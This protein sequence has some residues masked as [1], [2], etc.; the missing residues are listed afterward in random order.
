[1]IE[2]TSPASVAS[3]YTQSGQFA[4]ISW[5]ILQDGSL[6]QQ[7]YTGVRDPGSPETNQTS[8][9]AGLDESIYRIYSMTKPVVSSAIIMLVQSDRLSLDTPLANF[10]PAANSQVVLG[11]DGAVENRQGNI[12]I[13]HLLTHRGGFSYD[14]LPDCPVADLYRE[15]EFAEDGS[16]DLQ[17]LCERLC[18]HPLTA[19]PGKQWI[20]SYSTDL[21]GGILEQ[22]TDT[23]LD[24]FLQSE[25]F[26]PLDMS[27]TGYQVHP[28][29]QQM[30]KPMFGTR[31]LSAPMDPQDTHQTLVPLDVSRSYPSDSDQGFRRGGI[32][33][34]STMTDYLRFCEFL[35]T[36]QTAD[37]KNLIGPG[38]HEQMWQNRL[39]P[40]E[41]PISIGPNQY[42]GY[43]WNLMGRVM[44]DTDKAPVPANLGEGGWA[45]AASTYF[46]I[47]R[48][49]KLSGVVLSQYLGAS[50]KLGQEIQTA[51][52][53]Q[54]AHQ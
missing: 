48:Q 39:E 12:T 10:Y 34:F 32:G 6:I 21:L 18:E 27:S 43:G 44:V 50:V 13:E 51:A 9:L 3:H 15:A 25:L 31:N 37:G 1:M 46:W 47:D 36:G 42:C 54:S 7:G 29:D 2:T 49:R 23:P 16:R 11:S 14:F 41:R 45:G 53:H 19:Q 40:H 38:L 20:Y 26:D 17:V 24:Q 8:E 22:V 4:S 28:S 35:R 52:D 5:A 33:L 30:I